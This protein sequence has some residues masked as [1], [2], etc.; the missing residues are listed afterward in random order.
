MLV[1]K[2]LS[3]IS[4]CIYRLSLPLLPL[5]LIHYPEFFTKN[6]CD[7]E[8]QLSRDFWRSVVSHSPLISRHH[9]FCKCFRYLYSLFCHAMYGLW[10]IWE[11]S[12]LGLRRY[13]VVIVSPHNFDG[14]G[15]PISYILTYIFTWRANN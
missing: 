14:I 3:C 7:L 9:E 10:W 2:H 4:E 11:C 5:S 6:S 13:L 12:S 1:N 15:R 8:L